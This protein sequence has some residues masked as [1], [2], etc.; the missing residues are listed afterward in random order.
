MFMVNKIAKISKI[1]EKNFSNVEKVLLPSSKSFLNRALILASISDKKVVLNGVVDICQDVKDMIEIL[2]NLGVK[3]EIKNSKNEEKE[4]VIYGNGGKFQ[5]PK[6]GILNCGLGGTTT[7]FLLGLSALFDFEI[8]ITA[9]GKMLERP[10]GEILEVLKKLGKNV[11]FLQKNSCLPVRIA[12][13][14]KHKKSIEI[15]GSKSS[16]FVS[17][18]FLIANAIGVEEVIVKNLVSK[19][20][21]NMTLKI[22]QNFGINFEKSTKKNVIFY[23]KIEEKNREKKQNLKDKKLE[24][25]VEKDFSS[26]SY[27]LALQ[28]IFNFKKNVLFLSKNSCQGDANFIK[29]LKK[30]KNFEKKS[31]NEKSVKKPLVLNMLNMP[32]VSMTAMIVC[33]LCN[34]DTKIIGLKTLKNKECN[35]L[36]AMQNEFAKIGVKTEISKN[37]NSI[38][39]HGKSDFAPKKSVKIETYNDHRIAMCFAILGTKIGNLE[40]QNCDVVEKS[41]PNFWQ[42]LNKFECVKIV[43]N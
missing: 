34:F 6:N 15:D 9:Q 41:F 30:I 28:A 23:K 25:E 1:T 16:Q 4:I 26:A 24:I 12:G 5:K 14:I 11:E 42:E 22:L 32:D 40:I 19:P 20:Y 18:V 39:I 37:W 31:K 3:I 17:S 43:E 36:L 35:R 7:R 2:Q 29:I 13:K 33:C 38:I 21:V 27:F 8:T 10:V